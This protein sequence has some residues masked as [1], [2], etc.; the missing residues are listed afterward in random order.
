[1]SHPLTLK[2]QKVVLR[3][4]GVCLG[5]RACCLG[6]TTVSVREKKMDDEW[7]REN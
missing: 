7:Q 5:T 1:M 2:K 4:L 3:D 6:L